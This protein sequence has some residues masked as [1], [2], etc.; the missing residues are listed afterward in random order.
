M[1]MCQMPGSSNYVNFTYVISGDGYFQDTLSLFHEDSICH[2]NKIFLMIALKGESPL[3][4]A[5]VFRTIQLLSLSQ[6]SGFC[7][8]QWRNLFLL[9]KSRQLQGLIQKK[10]ALLIFRSP[11]LYPAKSSTPENDSFNHYLTIAQLSLFLRCT[12]KSL[13]AE[14][15]PLLV[16][17]LTG[18]FRNKYRAPKLL[19]TTVVWRCSET[20]Q[21]LSLDTQQLLLKRSLSGELKIYSLVFKINF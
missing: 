13:F 1:A 16:K 5:S 11:K 9:R 17:R 15:I 6:S 20:K 19:T 10:Y 8:S 12:T 4:F 3:S 21:L 2:K 14:E 18:S 7:T